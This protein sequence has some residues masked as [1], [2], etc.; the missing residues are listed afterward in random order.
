MAYAM[1]QLTHGRWRVLPSAQ[2]HGRASDVN[3]RSKDRLALASF[4]HRW[5]SRVARAIGAGHQETLSPA[6]RCSRAA[7]EAPTRR[8]DRGGSGS[9]TR[10][11]SRREPRTQLDRLIC[12]AEALFPM[13]T[14]VHHLH[15]QGFQF[16]HPKSTTRSRTSQSSE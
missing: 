6:S 11:R 13:P 12:I 3:H 8:F 5:R 15:P 2:A 4:R 7:R 16:S 9:R 14:H 10:A 1:S